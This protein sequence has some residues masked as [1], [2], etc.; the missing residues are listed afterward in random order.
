MSSSDFDPLNPPPLGQP[1][2]Y[3]PP[4]S[5]QPGTLGVRFLARIIDGILVAI[6][7]FVLAL[8]FGAQSNILVT[9]LFSGV[10]MFIYFVAL[11][12]SQGA[13]IGKKLLGLR[14]ARTGRRRQA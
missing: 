5:G 2:G 6:V 8:V 9:G 7:A 14:R 13:S 3:P 1:A 12:V 11:E 10:L 4:L